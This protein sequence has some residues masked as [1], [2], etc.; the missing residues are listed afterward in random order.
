MSFR[1]SNS[2]FRVCGLMV[3]TGCAPQTPDG[4]GDKVDPTPEPAA[5]TA[6]PVQARPRPKESPARPT[7]TPTPE[8]RATFDPRNPDWSLRYQMLREYY[9]G[10]FEPKD[11][12]VGTRMKI[13][14]DNGSV[15]E[16]VIAA[17]H[18]DSLDLEIDNGILNLHADILREDAQK[19]FFEQYFAQLSAAEQAK[20]EFAKWKANQARS[21]MP[22][23]A[24]T[25]SERA[26]GGSLVPHTMPDRDNPDGLT[27]SYRPKAGSEAPKNEGPKG[28]VW[29]VDQ[30]LRKN[31]AVPHSLKYKKWF[32]GEK[33]GRGYKVRVQYSVESAA[34]L[35]TSHEDM[36]FFMYSDGRV[37]QRAAVK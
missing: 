21:S 8:R 4:D 13:P 25:P 7:P 31:S 24:P 16:G 2:I 28:R 18:E 34:N 22:R 1:F 11:A 17:I 29:Q 15:R 30:Y 9:I 37:Y 36:M 6:P 26:G 5:V 35:G 14:L 33:H 12:R 20:E 10:E 3:L 32:P 23:P 19:Y 27:H